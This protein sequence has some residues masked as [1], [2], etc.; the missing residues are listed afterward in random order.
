MIPIANMVF[1][2]LTFSS[3]GTFLIKKQSGPIKGYYDKEDKFFTWGT[4]GIDDKKMFI[5]WHVMA[6]NTVCQC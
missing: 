3:T 2:I 1:A 6:V 4:S 5:E